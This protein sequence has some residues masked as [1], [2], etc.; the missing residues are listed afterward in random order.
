MRVSDSSSSLRPRTQGAP[1]TRPVS[2][3]M[4]TNSTSGT[5]SREVMSASSVGG[6]KIQHKRRAS[7]EPADERMPASVALVRVPCCSSE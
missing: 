5:G 7:A 1:E 3:V 6:R 2:P 4:M